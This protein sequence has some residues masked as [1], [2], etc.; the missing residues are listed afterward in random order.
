M[1]LSLIFHNTFF[2]LICICIEST[3]DILAKYRTPKKP[4]AK[5]TTNTTTNNNNSNSVINN[6]ISASSGGKDSG[7]SHI[8]RVGDSIDGTGRGGSPSGGA[9]N[10]N[11]GGTSGNVASNNNQLPGM[12][13]G[14][15]AGSIPAEADEP[16]FFDPDN[17]EGCPAFWDAKRKLR[18]V[19]SMGDAFFNMTQV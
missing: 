12:S 14:G 16:P 1:I 3:D 11:V 17:L 4:V 9:N 7:G 2:C 19:L 5:A 10:E 6:N 18:I 15:G 8:S 13:S